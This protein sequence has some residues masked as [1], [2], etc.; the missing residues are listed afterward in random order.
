MLFLHLSRVC[1]HYRV[2]GNG[3][4]GRGVCEGS[5]LRGVCFPPHLAGLVGVKH[6]VFEEEPQSLPVPL[7]PLTALLSPAH[8]G[9]L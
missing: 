2:T 1:V 9:L 8:R 6:L 3:G 7:A 5:G 4:L